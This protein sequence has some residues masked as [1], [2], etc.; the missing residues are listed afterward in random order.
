MPKNNDNLV[1]EYLDYV[2][3]LWIVSKFPPTFA[4]DLLP[5]M[6]EAGFL[7]DK[8]ISSVSGECVQWFGQCYD[9][10]QVMYRFEA[11]W[12]IDME[13]FS[14]SERHYYVL[15]DLNIEECYDSRVA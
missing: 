6:T 3:G 5:I 7:I 2:L 15:T 1:Q 13:L 8:V 10:N 14:K 11:K 4:Q 9:E 12:M